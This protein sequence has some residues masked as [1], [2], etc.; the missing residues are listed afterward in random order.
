QNF[1]LFA[2]GPGFRACKQPRAARHPRAPEPKSEARRILAAL[3]GVVVDTD[4]LP[5]TLHAAGP[6]L[7]GFGLNLH[8]ERSSLESLNPASSYWFR[9]AALSRRRRAGVKN[10]AL[11][12]VRGFQVWQFLRAA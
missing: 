5:G 10:P 9:V 7:V 12:E 6:R 11:A 1:R 8:V 4:G 2:V 3:E